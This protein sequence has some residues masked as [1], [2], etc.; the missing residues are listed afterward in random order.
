MIVKM[1]TIILVYALNNKVFV[2]YND[3]VKVNSY[4][5]MRY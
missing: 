2:S 4:N 5:E 3:G 1:T